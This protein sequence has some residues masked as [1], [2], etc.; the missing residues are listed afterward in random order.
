M[1]NVSHRDDHPFLARVEEERTAGRAP[2]DLTEA[3]PSRCGLAWSAAEIEDLLSASG[4]GNDPERAAREAREAVSSYLA[5]RGASVDP[6]RVLL[7]S[8]RGGSYAAILDLLCRGD[9]EVL[10][11]SPS[12]PFLDGLAARRSVRLRRYPLVYDGGW[13]IDRKALKRMITPRT[14]AIVIGNPADPTGAVLMADELGFLEEVCGTGAV[15]L[16]GDE[17]FV[18]TAVG[19]CPSVCEARECLAFHVSGLSGVCGLA[20][21]HAEWLALGGPDAVVAPVVA[22]LEQLPERAASSAAQVASIAPLLARR[23]RYLAALR[24]RLTE[25]RSYLAAAAL[26][27]APWSLHWGAGGCWAVIQIGAAEEEE[28][29]CL[30]LLEDGVVVQPGSLHGLPKSGFLVVS[31]LP[32]PAI[33]REGLSR[34]DRRLRGPL[35]G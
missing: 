33:F 20:Q 22:R 32:E 25:N 8:S 26:R 27:E 4:S 31:L 23:E 29:L 11:P 18:D 1:S 9:D 19:S 34:L 21:L 30:A 35:L 15:A 12:R 3:D 7:S 28:P 13:R 6:G 16:V 2:L 17:A 24:V 10:I 5:G 14:R